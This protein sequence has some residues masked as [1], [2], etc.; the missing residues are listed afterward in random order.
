LAKISAMIQI[1]RR[2]ITH[3]DFFILL[4]IIP[5]ALSSLFLISE[6]N[7]SL[8]TKEM[9]Y[10]IVGFGVLILFSIIPIRKLTWLIPII[11]W[12]DILLLVSVKF[13]GVSILGAQRW[14]E[15]PFTSMTLQPSEIIKPALLLMLAYLIQKNPPP[16]EG[17]GL[18][19]FAKISF[20]ILLPFFLIAIEPDLGSAGVV[21]ILGFGIL[22]LVGVQWRIWAVLI[23][24]FLTMS[25]L[26]YEF[27]LRDYQKQRVEDF[28]AEK[29]S[30]HVQ[31]SII[32]IGSGGIFG[33][34]KE[35]ATQ[36]Q[37]KFLPIATTDFIFA[38][39][40]ERFGFFG[41][42]LLITIYSTLTLHILGLRQKFKND[43]FSV[44]FASGIGVLIFVYSSINIAM[45]IGLAP[46]VGIPLPMYSYGGTS[47]VTFMILFGILENLLA[48]RF[49][50]LYNSVSFSKQ[51]R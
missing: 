38:Y 37:L 17:Y 2:I 36:V 23:A 48:F 4:L 39:H 46:V 12:V 9:A 18:K 10:I 13:F 7:S 16:Q 50:F 35:D 32:A 34:D 14:L 47:F 8:A 30:Y 49:N 24:V 19:A 28:L 51:K 29:P 33:K 20:Y 43:H 31:Q 44:V 3:F 21:F 22:F 27:G 1:D 42:F 40:V 6:V 15:I 11:Y 45:T 25:T 41:A 5:I 26:L